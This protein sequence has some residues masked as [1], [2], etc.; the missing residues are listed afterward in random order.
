MIHVGKDGNVGEISLSRIEKRNAIN[1]ELLDELISAIR[2]FEK[3]RDLR[4]VVLDS[5]IDDFSVGADIR[6]LY[7]MDEE[8]ARSFRS[9]MLSIAESMVRSE[10]IFISYL[11]GYALGGGFELSQWTDIIIAGKNSKIGQPEVNIGI[12]AGAGGNT[13]LPKEIGY[14]N[15]MYLALTGKILSAVEAKEKG[16]VQEVVNSKEE[17]MKIAKE[18]ASKDALTITAIKRSMAKALKLEPAEDM[19]AEEDAFIKLSQSKS[20]KELLSEFLNK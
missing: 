18:I 11:T 9:K 3:D 7:R 12:N 19:K 4:V 13:I 6:D 5:F 8:N 14:K 17:M 16:I 15:A 2:D 20:T 10:K 1:Q